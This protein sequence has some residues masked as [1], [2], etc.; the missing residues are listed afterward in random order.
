MKYTITIRLINH[1][2]LNRKDTISYYMSGSKVD[3][4]E[5]SNSYIKI[6]ANR[7]KKYSENDIFFNVQNSLYNQ[8]YKCLLFHYV[9][10]GSNSQIEKIAIDVYSALICTERMLFRYWKNIIS[11]E[12]LTQIILANYQHVLGS[13]I[14]MI[15]EK[16]M[17]QKQIVFLLY[18]VFG[19]K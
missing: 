13:W 10:N 19:K 5:F 1:S 15:C 18:F 17:R 7:N 9:M 16:Y 6:V 3:T 4:V 8:M 14:K 11:Q 2:I 12:K